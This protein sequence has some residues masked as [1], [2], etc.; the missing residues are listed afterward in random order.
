MNE[1]SVLISPG[2][3]RGQNANAC[4]WSVKTKRD[5]YKVTNDP[6]TTVP[7]TLLTH[8]LDVLDDSFL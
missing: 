6:A 7:P 4:S 1:Y 3:E 5:I 2:S 8:L